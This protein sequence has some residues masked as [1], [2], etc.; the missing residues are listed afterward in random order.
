MPPKVRETLTG[1]RERIVF[2]FIGTRAR[3][4]RL[5]LEVID[6]CFSPFAPFVVT[7]ADGNYGKHSREPRLR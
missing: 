4:R 1:A 3:F 7:L 5:D 2:E 6:S